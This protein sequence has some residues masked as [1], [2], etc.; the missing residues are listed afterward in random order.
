MSRPDPHDPVEVV[1]LRYS[2]PPVFG[3]ASSQARYDLRQRALEES[4]AHEFVVSCGCTLTT[5]RGGR[6]GENEAVTPAG[7]HADVA[8]GRAALQL[9]AQRGIVVWSDPAVIAARGRQ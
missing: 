8:R 5:E 9:L 1:G 7:V 3:D 6:F 4:A 2:R